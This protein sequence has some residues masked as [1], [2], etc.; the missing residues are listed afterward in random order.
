MTWKAPTRS[1]RRP[2]TDVKKRART[3]RWLAIRAV[4]VHDSTL[5]L[6]EPTAPAG[7]YPGVVRPDANKV[8]RIGPVDV[9]RKGFIGVVGAT[10]GI[11]TGIVAP[12]SERGVYVWTSRMP[13]P[14][15]RD[16]FTGESTGRDQAERHNESRSA[17][18]RVFRD[19]DR[20]SLFKSVQ[21]PGPT[22]NL[23]SSRTDHPSRVRILLTQSAGLS[24]LSETTRRLPRSLARPRI[25]LLSD[26][27][28]HK[29]AAT[30]ASPSIWPSERMAV[31]SSSN[32]RVARRGARLDETRDDCGE[33]KRYLRLGCAPAT[34]T[35]RGP[36]QN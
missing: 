22:Q 2:L 11:V 23:N 29:S 27:R 26:E 5:A 6:V 8:G 15:L 17:M 33:R 18:E 24:R 1:S 28:P 34:C 14:P 31:S 3:F 12:I 19:H 21:S 30:T 13:A 4:A 25:L 7:R 10:S 16:S 35:L 9:W 20:P 32:R 36:R